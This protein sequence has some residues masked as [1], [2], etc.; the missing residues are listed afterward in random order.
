MPDTRIC[1]QVAYF[2]KWSQHKEV[3]TGKNRNRIQGWVVGLFTL[4]GNWRSNPSEALWDAMENQNLQNQKRGAFVRW[5]PGHVK[6]FILAGMHM[7]QNSW[8]DSQRRATCDGR[9]GLAQ[10]E[11]CV[12]WYSWET[13]V[14]LQLHA[15]SFQSNSRG[16]KHRLSDMK[17]GIKTVQHRE[18]G[19]GTWT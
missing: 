4:M 11:G 12:Y 3:K 8:V 13:V 9:D 17:W 18:L 1:M 16:W 6:S 2:W 19:D 10:K 5:L 15:A 7:H 14:W